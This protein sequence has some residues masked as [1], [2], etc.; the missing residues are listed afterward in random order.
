MDRILTLLMI[1]GASL[2]TTSAQEQV[3]WHLDNLE[4]IGGH[5]VTVEGEP[6]VIDTPSGKAIEFDGVDDGIFLDVH[7]MAG[8][9][10]FTV[11]VIFRP[12]KDGQPEQRFSKKR[13]PIQSMRTDFRGV[14]SY[15]QQFS[16]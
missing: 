2:G 4:K 9:S 14:T 16:Q 8:W 13:S 6:K 5:A 1:V 15:S 11:E 7:P 3:V 10:T 12:Y